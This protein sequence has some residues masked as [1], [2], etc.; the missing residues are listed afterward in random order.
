MCT[1]RSSAPR[2]AENGESRVLRWACVAARV[3]YRGGF[4]ISAVSSGD[5]T[6]LFYF[7]RLYFEYDL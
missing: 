4:Q 6:S 1:L 7:L 5:L 3:G 2:A